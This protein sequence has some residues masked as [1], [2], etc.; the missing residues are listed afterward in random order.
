ME[1]K[2][3]SLDKIISED[4]GSDLKKARDFFKMAVQDIL[5]SSKFRIENT[6]RNSALTGE[7]GLKQVGQML[8]RIYNKI[9]EFKKKD[10]DIP[11]RIL[12]MVNKLNNDNNMEQKPKKS[13]KEYK[14][15]I[16]QLVSVENYF[17]KSE[18]KEQKIKEVY[19]KIESSLKSKNEN[20][21]PSAFGSNAVLNYNRNE[22]KSIVDLQEINSVDN[23]SEEKKK[24]IEEWNKIFTMLTQSHLWNPS[25]EELNNI[26][27]SLKSGS[28]FHIKVDWQNE[29]I[30]NK[31]DDQ[32]KKLLEKME[33]ENADRALKKKC[34][35]Y[36]K[37]KTYD[38]KDDLFAILD[39]I[40]AVDLELCMK[41]LDALTKSVEKAENAE[42]GEKNDNENKIIISKE[43]NPT[44]EKAEKVKNIKEQLKHRARLLGLNNSDAFC[45][46]IDK[47]STEPIDQFKNF[48][49]NCQDK[50]DKYQKDFGSISMI[51]SL[52]KNEEEKKSS[53]EAV[54][55]DIV[56]NF[57]TEAKKQAKEIL[58]Q[59]KND[60]KNKD[61]PKILAVEF[62]L[63]LMDN[64]DKNNLNT[65]IS[66]RLQFLANVTKQLDEKDD[67]GFDNLQSIVKIMESNKDLKDL[68]DQNSAGTF[69][70]LLKKINSDYC[71]SILD[72][73]NNLKGDQSVN[74]F[75]KDILSQQDK[76]LVSDFFAFAF[77][78]KQN[79]DQK[80]K[81]TKKFLSVIVGQF[82]VNFENDFE[83]G[84]FLSL[85][86]KPY[87]DEKIS[88]ASATEELKSI[89][90]SVGS[91]RENFCLS[92]D[93][94]TSLNLLINN[95]DKIKDKD[96]LEAFL[97][98]YKSTCKFIDENDNKYANRNLLVDLQDIFLDK[99]LDSKVAIENISLVVNLLTKLDKNPDDVQE[100]D[101]EELS[102]VLLDYEEKLIKDNI[103]NK[104]PLLEATLK[105][106]LKPQNLKV[107]VTGEKKNLFQRLVKIKDNGLPD[108]DKKDLKNYF[109]SHATEIFQQKKEFT[110]AE[111]KEF[112]G[113][114]Q[115]E[116]KGDNQYFKLLDSAI[117][118][119][120]LS[121]QKSLVEMLNQSDN[122]NNIIALKNG[123]KEEKEKAYKSILKSL[124]KQRLHQ[125]GGFVSSAYI[126]YYEQQIDNDN[127]EITNESHNKIVS[128]VQ[129]VLKDDFQPETQILIAALDDL[130]DNDNEAFLVFWK[131]CCKSEKDERQEQKK[132][133]KKS[134]VPV[135]NQSMDNKAG[136]NSKENELI[137]DTSDNKNEKKDISNNDKILDALSYIFIDL[138][139]HD[140]SKVNDENN[141][142]NIINEAASL[143]LVEIT[144]QFVSSLYGLNKN[145]KK[146][147]DISTKSGEKEK[148]N[149]LQEDN[150]G[151]TK[152]LNGCYNTIEKNQLNEN[153]LG[154]HGDQAL[155]NQIDNFHNLDSDSQIK[156]LQ[157]MKNIK[158][159][160]LTNDDLVYI[161]LCAY[162]I[163]KKQLDNP[164]KELK[165]IT[166]PNDNSGKTL[167]EFFQKYGGGYFKKVGPKKLDLT[168]MT[169]DQIKSV[170]KNIGKG[171]ITDPQEKKNF[172]GAVVFVL[173]KQIQGLKDHYKNNNYKAI[174]QIEAGYKTYWKNLIGALKDKGLV[175]E[176]KQAEFNRRIDSACD[177]YAVVGV[178]KW[179]LAL[180]V[181]IIALG[182]LPLASK[183]IRKTLHS[184][185][186]SRK[187]RHLIKSINGDNAT[188]GIFS[189]LH[190]LAENNVPTQRNNMESNE[191]Q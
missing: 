51:S 161:N 64:V 181:S 142:N 107:F 47:I 138:L 4:C 173:E 153:S 100:K 174:D 12:E 93:F 84:K 191:L 188:N 66:Q 187:T 183:T 27:S 169:E 32:Q 170:I 122:F 148:N 117:D 59:K 42:E 113:F 151:I 9:E 49:K 41:E 43:P 88:R 89:I 123:K 179:I 165:L 18:G 160:S 115:D 126:K 163:K 178:L 22:F 146:T 38:H 116:K 77:D 82:F 184:P 31:L 156:L 40:A 158:N 72:A 92:T 37:S 144:K 21:I 1:D 68:L 73:I 13:D 58:K 140:R 95:M 150:T 112:Y 164:F 105:F 127:N 125:K 96:D 136:N 139:E 186:K 39:A 87:F 128:G 99:N 85:V 79:V 65:E 26:F 76:T 143:N 17:D 171:E 19:D 45:D 53:I 108:E 111:A 168:E 134:I 75:L 104:F 86:F 166:D 152:V 110:E 103:A 24:E 80:L 63:S 15:F 94:E 190:D 35:E 101:F 52:T 98:S 6:A 70:N 180:L 25:K 61:N 5:S 106:Q 185:L 172:A 119:L 149:Q 102:G 16:A 2:V 131:S 23:L 155:K 7:T 97:D 141:I 135:N 175:S 20:N 189:M 69:Y 132:E 14:N 129:N 56:T 83:G 137:I 34:Q 176:E 121:T 157:C 90:E 44:K 57:Y 133:E 78:D 33:Q 29:S 3:K 130:K 154:K 124:V 159:N 118:T 182:I 162:E 48:V 11:I 30:Y 54:A 147:E 55:K 67:F 81:Y 50:F 109:W 28:G 10:L 71:K 74:N 36:I 177:L 62:V 167:A 114:I 60:D 145:A 91:F 120:G 8:D 46:V